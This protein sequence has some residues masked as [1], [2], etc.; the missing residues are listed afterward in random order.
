MRKIVEDLN[1]VEKC[2]KIFH[3]NVSVQKPCLSQTLPD[4]KGTSK[5]KDTKIVE[6]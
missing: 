6:R 5:E 2:F 1:V 4:G 3:K